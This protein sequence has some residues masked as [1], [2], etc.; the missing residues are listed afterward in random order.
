MN[1]TIVF[2]RKN[3]ALIEC[4]SFSDIKFSGPIIIETKKEST[5]KI[6]IDKIYN[7]SGILN[8]ENIKKR[9]SSEI[10]FLFRDYGIN[11]LKIKL[12]VWLFNIL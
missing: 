3:R 8:E 7:S 4:D 1:D 5:I 9:Q 12:F 10:E 11:K 2:H 6:N